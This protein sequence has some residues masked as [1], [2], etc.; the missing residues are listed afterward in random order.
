QER[1]SAMEEKFD[2]IIVGGG[3]AGLSAAMILAREGARFLLIERGEFAGSKN[4]SGGVLWGDDLARLVPEYWN[5]DSGIERFIRHR[6]LTFMDEG[7]AFSLDFK[8]DHY[9]RPPYVGV[10]V[11]RARFDNWLA[12]KVEEAIA[13]SDQPDASFLATNIL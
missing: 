4:V 10:T 13:G 11:L 8:S 1:L 12:G 9:D 3:I 2:C 5:D 6:R 7:S